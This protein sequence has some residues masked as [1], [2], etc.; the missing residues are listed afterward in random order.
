MFKKGKIMNPKCNSDLSPLFSESVEA[1]PF[2]PTVNW[3]KVGLFLE[4]IK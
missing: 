3:L 1:V 2:L 4:V